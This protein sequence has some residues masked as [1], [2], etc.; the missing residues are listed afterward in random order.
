M[1]AHNASYW[2]NPSMLSLG[3]PDYLSLLTIITTTVYC[4]SLYFMVEPL[5]ADGAAASLAIRNL[6]TLI[7]GTYLYTKVIANKS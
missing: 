2:V 3:R 7:L 5:K 6:V 1:I 4:I